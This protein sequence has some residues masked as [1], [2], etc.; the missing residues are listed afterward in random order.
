MGRLM[1]ITTPDLAPGFQLAGVDTFAVEDA[2]QAQATLSQLLA[3]DEASLIIVRQGLLEAMDLHL[4][5][6]IRHSY[7]PVVI[8]IPGRVPVVPGRSRQRYISEIIRRAIGFRITFGP[9]APEA[10]ED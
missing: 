1:V 7:R 3:G 5:R 6:Q 2:D 9:G 10:E 4:Q 8:A